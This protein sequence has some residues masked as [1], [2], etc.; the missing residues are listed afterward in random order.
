MLKSKKHVF[1]EALFVTILVFF[2]GIFIGLSFEKNRLD[3]IDKYYS[4]SEVSFLDILT[5]QKMQEL[6]ASNCDAIINAQIKFADKIYNEAIILEDYEDA[7]KI[8]DNLKISHKKYDLLRT[9][10]WINSLK[11]FENCPKKFVP[12]AYLYSYN[13]EEIDKKATQKTL[14]RVLYDLKQKY[15]DKIL[16]LP[17]AMDNNLTSVELMTEQLGIKSFPCI[18]IGNKTI[19]Y[20]LTSISK[21]EQ[22]LP[23]LN[24]TMIKLN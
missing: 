11:T 4:E 23:F 16:L 15:G 7:N 22:N 17:I 24:N 14:S 13:T 10:L 5:L 12:I 1:W 18:I 6:N 8:N 9:Y 19:L 21:I 20:N 3:V 2:S